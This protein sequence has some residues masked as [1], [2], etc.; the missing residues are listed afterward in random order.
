MPPAIIS[1]ISGERYRYCR[2]SAHLLT[3][4]LDS[5]KRVLDILSEKGLLLLQDKQLPN[6]VSIVTGETLRSS[7]WSHAKGQ[8]IFNVLSELSEHGD[9]LFLKLLGGKVTLIH[10]RLWPALLTI[11][12]KAAP[13]QLHGL[14]D[15]AQ[16]LLA[17]VKASQKPVVHT[18]G[19]V[20]ELERRLLVHS[21]ERHTESGRHVI[22]VQSWL[23]WAK[24]QKLKPLRSLGA[25]KQSIE[26]AVES[27]GAEL[28]ALPWQSKREAAT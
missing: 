16:E 25:A 28:S 17:S 15:A 27:M 19:A 14:S 8:L 12:A 11:V 1:L 20:K 21:Q 6:V 5:T 22:A 24:H 18:G 9:V 7:W 23:V 2:N 4:M 10:R 3:K 13:W 26:N